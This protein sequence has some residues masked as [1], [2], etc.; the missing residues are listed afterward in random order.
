MVCEKLVLLTVFV[1]TEVHLY[2]LVLQERL[3]KQQE[4]T[5]DERHRLQQLV[6][7]LEAQIREQ[8]RMLEE[9]SFYSPVDKQ[10]LKS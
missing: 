9:V 6:A 8:T 2:I 10:S 7:R 3:Q 5:E 1:K 4:D